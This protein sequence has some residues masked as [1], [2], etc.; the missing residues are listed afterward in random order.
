MRLNLTLS[1]FIMLAFSFQIGAQWT[2]ISG[3]PA[4]FVTDHSVGFA[5]DGKGYLATGTDEL[6]NRR[7]DVYEYDPATDSFTKKGN[8]PGGARGFSIGD[9]WNGKA[10]LGFGLNSII[11]I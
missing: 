2:E 5:L 11:N 6:G 9:T 1:T 8:F 4:G 10:Y 3:P 7:N